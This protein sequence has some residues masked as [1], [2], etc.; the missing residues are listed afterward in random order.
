MTEL[1]SLCEESRFLGGM[2]LTTSAEAGNEIVTGIG[3][4][5]IEFFKTTKAG[6]NWTNAYTL[7]SSRPMCAK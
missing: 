2:H 7:G 5:V 1:A 6:S 3:E 4:L